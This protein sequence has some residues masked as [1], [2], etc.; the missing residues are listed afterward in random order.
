MSYLLNNW[1]KYCYQDKITEEAMN[2]YFKDSLSHVL[3]VSAQNYFE[4]DQEKVNRFLKALDCTKPIWIDLCNQTL[5]KVEVDSSGLLSF[6]D[7]SIQDAGQQLNFSNLRIF[8][9]FLVKARLFRAKRLEFWQDTTGFIQDKASYDWVCVYRQ[10]MLD[11]R[12]ACMTRNLS[13]IVGSTKIGE[14]ILSIFFRYHW[15]NTRQHKSLQAI[16]A[17]TVVE[18]YEALLEALSPKLALKPNVTLREARKVFKGI[19]KQMGTANIFVISQPLH[20]S[21]KI[22]D[23]IHSLASQNLAKFIL[24]NPSEKNMS[25]LEDLGENPSSLMV[26]LWEH[27]EII[28]GNYLYEAQSQK[29]DLTQIPAQVPLVFY[30]DES[31]SLNRYRVLDFQEIKE[32]ILR[33]HCR[34]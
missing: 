30:E 10:I 25:R 16:P 9:E 21:N 12:D 29:I 13:G 2:L 4:D 5:S 14:V 7:I 23:E 26:K 20:Y 24:I 15:H 8:Q 19:G 11:I 1:R 33:N 31:E 27:K 34:S 28:E 17:A 18:F 6:S 3:S 32:I 22:I